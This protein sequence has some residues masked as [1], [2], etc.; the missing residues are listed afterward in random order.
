MAKSEK[1]PTE[2]R[3]QKNETA[4]S[5]AIAKKR[6]IFRWHLGTLSELS[7]SRDRSRE[8]PGYRRQRG[9]DKAG[10]TAGCSA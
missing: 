7:L 10:A 8:P 2:P 9:L 6:Y 5:R 3:V 4:T 1:L